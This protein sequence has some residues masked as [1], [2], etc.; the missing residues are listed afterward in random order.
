MSS[1]LKKLQR[2]VFVLTPQAPVAAGLSLD[3]F[4]HSV[5]ADGDIEVAMDRSQNLN[6]LFSQLNNNG[7]EIQSMRNKANRL[8]ELFLGLVDEKKAQQE[9][10]A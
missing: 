9:A 10:S 1:L 4:K 2:E 3:G 8:E 5:R 7:I 6:Q